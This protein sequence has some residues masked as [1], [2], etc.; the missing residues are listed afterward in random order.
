VPSLERLCSSA[1]G[2]FGETESQDSKR[3]AETLRHGAREIVSRTTRG[4]HDNDF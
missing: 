3:R 1:S 4:A 2:K